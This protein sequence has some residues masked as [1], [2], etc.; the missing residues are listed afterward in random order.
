M[1]T[2][3]FLRKNFALTTYELFVF[4]ILAKHFT[5]KQVAAFANTTAKRVRNLG[6]MYDVKWEALKFKTIRRILTSSGEL[7]LLPNDHVNDHVRRMLAGACSFDD[8]LGCPVVSSYRLR[9]RKISQKRQRV[10]SFVNSLLV[11][12]SKEHEN[13]GAEQYVQNILADGICMTTR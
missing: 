7:G 3:F 8:I 4:K 12:N 9:L 13:C 10:A 6:I 11:D 5:K 1:K 2:N